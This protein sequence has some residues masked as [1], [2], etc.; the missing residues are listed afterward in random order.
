MS[1]TSPRQA[2]ARMGERRGAYGK[3][4][5]KAV[6]E[7]FKAAKYY[8]SMDDADDPAALIVEKVRENA[9]YAL[10]FESSMDPTESMFSTHLPLAEISGQTGRRKILALDTAT[11]GHFFLYFPRQWSISE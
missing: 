10:R 4:A 11:I 8:R 1:D 3:S 6:D 9:T 2:I 7:I 5:I